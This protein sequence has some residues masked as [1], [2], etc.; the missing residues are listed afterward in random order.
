MLGLTLSD[1]VQQLGAVLLVIIALGGVTR[2]LWI[3][4]TKIENANLKRRLEN[5]SDELDAMRETARDLGKGKD[6]AL[7]HA[8]EE[9][10]RASAAE[11]TSEELR[12]QMESLPRYDDVIELVRENNLSAIDRQQEVI[13]AIG[14]L[15]EKI[16]ENTTA[17]RGLANGGTE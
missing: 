15:A 13:R 14:R 5:T 7:A 8:A 4:P 3:T 1:S 9:H 2:M 10:S 11:A 12:S 16:E 6:E 17:V